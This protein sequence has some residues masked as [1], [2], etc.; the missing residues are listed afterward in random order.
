MG[1]FLLAQ[2]P[3]RIV[4][5]TIFLAF[6]SV[7]NSFPTS[8]YVMGVQVRFYEPFLVM[9]VCY[10]ALRYRRRSRF[11]VTGIVLAIAFGVV[12]AILLSNPVSRIYID[13][14]LFIYLPMAYFVASR[15]FVIVNT[16]AVLRMIPWVLWISAIST[17]AA[18]ALG[19]KLAQM[20]SEAA[21]ST[22]EATR[23][24][25]PA[26]YAAVVVVSGVIALVIGG[27]ATIRETWIYWTP[28]L[29][30]M[31]LSFSRNILISIFVAGLFALVASRSWPA[32][33][34]LIRTVVVTV[35]GLGLLYWSL[36][37]LAGIPG[38][39]WIQAQ[40]DG[41]L[42]RVVGGIGG[43]AINQD[44]SAQFRFQQENAYLVAE[45]YESPLWGHGFGFAYKPINTGRAISDKSE[46]LQYYAHNFY[47]WIL[48]KAGLVGFLL[49]LI[50][51]ARV[52]GAALRGGGPVRLA[53]GAAAAGLLAVSI[54]APMPLGSPTAVL[55]GLVIGACAGAS[56]VDRR[57][58]GKPSPHRT[59]EPIV[60]AAGYDLQKQNS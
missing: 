7:P 36:S 54:V 39:S 45:I 16:R 31:L 25:G 56:A 9:S 51:I 43:Q 34:R 5:A 20:Q 38:V 11:G 17:I 49:M 10:V 15:F 46:N 27:Y 13:T 18:S 12:L 41:F 44:G 21:G 47:L 26:T 58:G 33:V 55:L 40:A 59:R 8:F 37:G 53:T 2:N 3:D 42:I 32:V 29:P 1:A 19:S 50:P 60:A 14:R 4:Y 48:V 30:L 23:L 28:A 52:L 57:Q 6:L 35:L 22:A 24:I